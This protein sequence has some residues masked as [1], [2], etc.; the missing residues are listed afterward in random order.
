LVG[1][2]LVGLMLGVTAFKP[3]PASAGVVPNKQDIQRLVQGLKLAPPAIAPPKL[4]PK[5]PNLPPLPY[6]QVPPALNPALAVLSPAEFVV[7]QGAYLGPLLGVVA[8]TV[9]LDQLPTEKVRIQPSFLSPAFGPVSTAC[10][11]A[12]FP[13]YT[14]CKQDAAINKAIEAAKPKQDLPSVGPLPTVDPFANVPAPFAS[15]VV[16]V[17]AI[18]NIVSFYGLNRTPIAGDPAGKLATQLACD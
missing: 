11:L 12:P 16:E 1:L 14:A 3:A 10:V 7:C 15:L 13:W 4:D 18:Q 6:V 5:N 8:L 9:L 2:T 17:D